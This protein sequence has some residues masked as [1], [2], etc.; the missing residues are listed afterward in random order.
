MKSQNITSYS[1]HHQQQFQL[2][3]NICLHNNTMLK[4]QKMMFMRIS[5]DQQVSITQKHKQ[6]LIC[7]NIR[8]MINLL[9]HLTLNSNKDTK[10]KQRNEDQLEDKNQKIDETED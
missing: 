1:I 3:N 8:K 4:I 6:L 2:T 10:T 9:Q 5:F 7:R